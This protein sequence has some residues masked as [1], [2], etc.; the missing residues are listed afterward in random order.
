MFN[1]LDLSGKLILVTG[2]SSGIGR[3]TAV[4]ISKLGAHAIISGRREKE[5]DQTLDLMENRSVHQVSVFDLTRL[6]DIVP[7]VKDLCVKA[8]AKLSGIVH[9]AGISNTEPFGVLS[10]STL[11]RT[12]VPNLYSALLLVKAAA[13]KQVLDERGCSV[14]LLS[15]VAALVGQ[16]GLATYGAS[17]AALH[18]VCRAAAKELA[19]KRIRVNCIAPGYVD[20][21]MFT[22]SMEYLPDHSVQA[23]I[24]QHHLGLIQ[25]DEVGVAAAYL[26]SDAAAKITGTTLVIDSGFSS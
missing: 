19:P 10:K 9:S 21:P 20:T 13:S 2:A 22:S 7:W 6:D 14:V 16:P 25:P 26:L 23:L 15:S 11:D 4:S 17:K 1:P 3:A 18:A 8:G 24:A 12:F 5:L